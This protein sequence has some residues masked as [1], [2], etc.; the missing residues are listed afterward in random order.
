MMVMQSHEK[1]KIEEGVSGGGLNIN[2]GF[3]IKIST[4]LGNMTGRMVYN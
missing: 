1:R 4:K 2:G 3:R